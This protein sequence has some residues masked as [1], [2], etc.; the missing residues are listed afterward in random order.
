MKAGAAVV[1]SGVLV[2]VATVVLGLA[3][4]VETAALDG[5]TDEL[6]L[7]EDH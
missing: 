2:L 7:A 5:L 3:E 6:L 4:V 1:A